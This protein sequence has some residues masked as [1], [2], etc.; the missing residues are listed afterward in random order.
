MYL[1][2]NFIQNTWVPLKSRTYKP[3]SIA[4]PC[5]KKFQLKKFQKKQV[6]IAWVDRRNKKH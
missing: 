2:Y 5:L 3:V 6:Y 4:A 1:T